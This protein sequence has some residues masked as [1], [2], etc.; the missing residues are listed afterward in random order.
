ADS[1]TIIRS[2]PERS[3]PLL[4]ADGEIRFSPPPDGRPIAVTLFASWCAPCRVEHPLLMALADSHPEQ[5]FGLAYKDQPP[6]TISFLRDLG[7]PYYAIGTDQ[8]G[9]GG[10]DFGLTGVPETFIIDADGT[11]VMHIRGIVDAQS[12]EEIRAILDQ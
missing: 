7:D 6:D 3:F 2:A 12:L 9:Q 10:L 5:V 1:G 8:D 11:I 4:S